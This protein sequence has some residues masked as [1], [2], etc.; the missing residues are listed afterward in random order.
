V[1]KA[2]LALLGALLAIVP[3]PAPM[4]AAAF[5]QIVSVLTPDVDPGTITITPT[6]GNAVVVGA[7]AYA[8]V[9]TWT[10]SSDRSETFT[11]PVCVLVRGNSQE[12]CVSVMMNAVGGVTNITINSSDNAATY[13]PMFAVEYS[14]LPTSGIVTDSETFA[15]NDGGTGISAPQDTK[16]YTPASGAAML[17]CFLDSLDVSVA[18]NNSETERAEGGTLNNLQVQDKRVTSASTCSWTW[19]TTNRVWGASIEME[20]ASAA[21]F[22]RAIINNPLRGGGLFWPWSR[23]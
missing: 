4:R 13:D 23:R 6:A 16:S 8:G 14:G 18:P 22:P 19:A 10:F 20:E 5:V 2:A 3:A 7:N 9:G 17:V 11:T 15:P 21:V 1:G 12:F